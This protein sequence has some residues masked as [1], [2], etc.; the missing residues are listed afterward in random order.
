MNIIGWFRFYRNM[1]GLWNF[2][3]DKSVHWAKKAGVGLAVGFTG[4]YIPWPFDLIPDF[5]IP[6]LAYL[7]DLG[8]AS[9]CFFILNWIGKNY[10]NR[11]LPPPSDKNGPPPA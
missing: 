5:L 9:L 7:D 11:Q 3:R 1:K 2:M 4:F 10:A 8:V 6:A